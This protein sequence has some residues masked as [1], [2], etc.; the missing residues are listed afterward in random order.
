MLVQNTEKGLV[1]KR[2]VGPNLF[3]QVFKTSMSL[4]I[5]LGMEV[6]Y[7]QNSKTR[8]ISSSLIVRLKVLLH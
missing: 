6:K 7:K 4:L 1:Q 2:G 8:D 3:F 5:K